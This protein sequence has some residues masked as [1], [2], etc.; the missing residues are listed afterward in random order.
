MCVTSMRPLFGLNKDNQ[1]M[2]AAMAES[3]GAGEEKRGVNK[4]H[5]AKLKVE[6][7]ERK[8]IAAALRP[9]YSIIYYLRHCSYEDIC[10][11][12]TT[13]DVFD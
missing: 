9:T 5:R 3:G 4:E 2:A 13:A 6:R 8:K 11:G 10:S 7:E 1:S 12:Y